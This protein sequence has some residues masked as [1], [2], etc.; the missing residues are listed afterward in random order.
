MMELCLEQLVS[1][2]VDIVLVLVYLIVGL[3]ILCVLE[4]VDVICVCVCVLGIGEC[5]VFDVDGCDFDWNQFDVSFNVFSLFSVCC[6]VEVCLF[7]GKLGKEGVEVISQF[8]VNLVLDVVLMIIVNEWSKVYQ[9]KWVEVVSCIGVLLVVWVIKLYELLDW[10]ECC[11]CGKGLCVDLVVVQCLVEWVEGNLLVVVQEIDKLVFLVDGQLLDVEWMELL[12]VDVVCYDVFWLV[13][14]IFFGQLLVVLC[15]LVGLCG[16]GEVVVVLML[17]VICELL[18]G[19][20][21]VCVQVCGGNLVVEMKLCGIWE[22]W[23]VFYKCVL[24]WYLEGKCWECFVVE[25]GLVDCIVKGCVDGD[26]WLVLEC[27]LVVVVELCVVCLLV[28]V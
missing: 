27:L 4:V 9:G 18:V 21:L 7:S 22:L 3:E 16:E 28:W 23:Q 10:I 11:L 8:C 19:V 24:Q 15:M 1:Q 20:G 5:E 6:L 17:I 25:V 13:E 26:V 2:G 14:V 12:V